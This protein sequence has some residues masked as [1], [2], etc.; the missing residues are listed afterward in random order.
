MISQTAR[1]QA[2]CRICQSDNLIP[3]L[4][5]GTTPLANA[6]VKKEDLGY[7]EPR[8][9][10]TV[11][12]CNACNLCQL[13][14]IVNPSILFRHYI[15]F[16]SVMP[17]LSDYFRQ[18]IKDIFKSE[19]APSKNDLV[20]EIGSNDGLFLEEVKKYRVRI[21]GVDPATNLSKIVKSRGVETIAEFFTEKL[22]Q[23]IVKKYGHSKIVIANNVVAHI[24]QH[25]DLMNG[26]KTLLAREGVFIFEFPY[27]VDMFQNCAFDTIYH[28][29][30]SYLALRPLTKLVR[31][32][33]MD[34]FDVQT[35]PV[36]GLSLRVFVGNKNIRAKSS[37][38][39][40]FMR[41]ELN[42]GLDKLA[43]Y[44]NL[45]RKIIKR[46]RE[47]RNLLKNLKRSGYTVAAYGAPAKGNTLLNYFNLGRDFLDFA[48]EEL[49]S[50]IG[51]YTPGTHIPVI[52]I[53]KAR[54][55]PPDY[56]LILAWNYTKVILE[57]E[58][59]LRTQGIKFIVPI[60]P[61]VQVI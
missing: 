45:T 18:Y 35:H 42:M 23:K 9:P 13:S 1:I 12:Y 36:Q 43:T 48:T 28:E 51:L 32:H 38:V 44:D 15:Y 60:G 31:S 61:N 58:K 22:A 50:K 29:H 11:L 25:H 56:F 47:V 19:F 5:L 8:F 10:L 27:L 7:K 21:L 55:N 37:S 20:V 16:S 54:Q 3:F 17:K 2:R 34:I 57:K 49:S 41:N 6:F 26:I 30:L 46:K 4:N 24:D 33:S 14:H 52:H 40:N 53:S 59:G 39:K